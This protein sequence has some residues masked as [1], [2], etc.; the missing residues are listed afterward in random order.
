MPEDGDIQRYLGIVA[1]LDIEQG[2]GL[3][4]WE[5]QRYAERCAAYYLDIASTSA[6][7]L[8][9]ML[10]YYHTEHTLVEALTDASHPE[11]AARWSEWTQQAL[12][13]LTAKCAGS[14]PIDV[15]AASLEDLAQDAMYDLWRG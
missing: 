3:M 2:W 5:Q 10:C 7:Q 1:E 13:L 4:P 6:A 14:L 11:H 12:R 8:R 9:T 15:A